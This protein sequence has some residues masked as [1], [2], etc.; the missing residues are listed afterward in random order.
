MH[1]ALHSLAGCHLPR[2]EVVRVLPPIRQ[3]D[4]GRPHS[5]RHLRLDLN[6]LSLACV[7][8]GRVVDASHAGGGVRRRPGRRFLPGGEGDA[9]AGR[10]GGS[11]RRLRLR[12]GR[13][14]LGIRLRF[15]DLDLGIDGQRLAEFGQ[16]QFRELEPADVHDTEMEVGS[17]R[18]GM[19]FEALFLADVECLMQERGGGLH[20]E[21]VVGD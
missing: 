2:Q 19:V 18:R 8:H 21:R 5:G 11:V 16:P 3:H 20:L 15:R 12:E 10:C 17:G 1:P 7:G 9:L 14:H 6:G 4:L 13:L